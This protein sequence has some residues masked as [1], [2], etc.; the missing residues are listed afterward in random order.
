MRG[1]MA[2]RD[3]VPLRESERKSERHVERK[4]HV[5]GR[6]EHLLYR[7]LAMIASE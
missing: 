7:T 6:R 2:R 3:R 5:E 1:I 4:V